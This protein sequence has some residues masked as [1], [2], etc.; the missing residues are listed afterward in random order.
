MKVILG[1]DP[2]VIT[3]IAI[4]DLKLE[5]IVVKSERNFSK[6]DIINFVLNFGEPIIVACDVSNPPKAVRRIA[7]VFGAKLIYPR[8]NLDRKRKEK[9]IRR[10][11]K[12]VKNNHERDAL[13][14]SLFAYNKI[15]H[16]IKKVEKI[17]DD[18]KILEQV[19]A[20]I[21]KEKR[22]GNI[23]QVLLKIKNSENSKN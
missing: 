12:Y 17:V 16:I 18:E 3:G 15:I 7:S 10:F 19:S 23:K 8:K 22:I 21:I 4:I 2:G 20:K 6:D 11:S 1:I 9:I 5:K 13:A 14:S